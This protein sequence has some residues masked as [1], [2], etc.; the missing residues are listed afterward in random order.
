MKEHNQIQKRK[1]LS[2][3]IKN[4]AIAEVPKTEVKKKRKQ[5]PFYPLKYGEFRLKKKTFTVDP[6][7]ITCLNRFIY[8]YR[9]AKIFKE[10]TV[11]DEKY[12]DK[13]I[14]GYS[15]ANKL[16]LT[17]TAYE[18]VREAAIAL[19]ISKKRYE[20]L[21]INPSL[22]AR[23]RKNVRLKELLETEKSKPEVCKGIARFY[24]S[25]YPSNNALQVAYMIRNCFGHGS[26]TT[27]GSGLNNKNYMN[28]IDALSEQLLQHCD[29]LFD[30]SISQCIIL[31]S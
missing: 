27:L 16:F 30:D 20:S 11:I 22:A 13:T 24:N 5:N 10:I 8:R 3:K 26:F 14:H 17:H 4:P 2:L 23:I 6:R 21:E 28:D 31:S 19:G 7:V 9:L 1:T 15:S 29:M 12:M 18:A 25:A